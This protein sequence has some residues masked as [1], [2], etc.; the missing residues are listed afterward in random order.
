MSGENIP[1]NK[2]LPKFRY[3]EYP[4][5]VQICDMLKNQPLI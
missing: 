2:K 1:E 3:I 4:E 5:F